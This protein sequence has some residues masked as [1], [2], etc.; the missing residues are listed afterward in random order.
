MALA[1]TPSEEQSPPAPRGDPPL[2]PFLAGPG[3]KVP[4]ARYLP[5]SLLQSLP[6]PGARALLPS[7]KTALP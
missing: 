4:F 3:R 1:Q 7:T 5:A 6:R 2:P